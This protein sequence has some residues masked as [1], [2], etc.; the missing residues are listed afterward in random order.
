MAT[1]AQEKWDRMRQETWN[2]LPKHLDHR[3]RQREATRS[4]VKHHGR[5]PSG[6][7]LHIRLGLW[8]AK[9]K[10]DS[11]MNGQRSRIPKLVLAG[12]FGLLAS[13][14]VID[15]ALAVPPIT[16]QEWL[17]IGN[18]ALVA[19]FAKFSNPEKALSHKPTV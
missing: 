1:P 8:Y 17:A 15:M 10:V 4:M 3:Q 11:L 13:Y 7:P 14:S 5:R 9:R 16:G 18:A 6:L 12:V 19:A 2:G